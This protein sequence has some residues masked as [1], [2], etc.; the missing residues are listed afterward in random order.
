M[1]KTRPQ[2]PF[3]LVFIDPPYGKDMLDPAL[4]LTLG[5]AWCDDGALICA[6]TEKDLDIAPKVLEGLALLTDRTYGQTR[7]RIWKRTVVK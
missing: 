3:Q 4:E 5:R 1:L 7:I 2:T 6:E